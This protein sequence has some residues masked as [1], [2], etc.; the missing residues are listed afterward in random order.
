MN[1]QF[2]DMKFEQLENGTVRLE[3]HDYCGESVIVDLHP[4]QLKFITRQVC[5]LSTATAV[6][7]K[8]LE[9][10]LS[11]LTSGIEA[12]V[13]DSGIRGEILDHCPA[14]LEFIAR[15]DAILNLAW[16]YD[17]ARLAPSDMRTPKAEPSETETKPT[18]N[19]IETRAATSGRVAGGEQM[20]LEV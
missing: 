12:F 4:E 17:G 14:G 6:Q 13:C 16:E 20:G 15:L 19:H 1:Q 5:G 9:R 18:G 7:V 3:Q 10:R 8:D 11:V 2:H